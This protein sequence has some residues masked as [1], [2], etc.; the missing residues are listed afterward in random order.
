MPKQTKELERHWWDWLS[1][2]ERLLRSLHEQTAALTLRRIERVEQIQP[3]LESMMKLMSEIDEQAA[4]SARTLAEELGCEPNLRSLVEALEKPEAE[5]V[6]AI[7]NRVIVVGRN[8]QRV[9]DKNKAL[10]EREMECVNGT[11][12]LVAK[13]VAEDE[14]PYQKRSSQASILMNQVA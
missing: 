9:I 6:Q 1:T 3:E 10:I 14:T 7:A 8:V 5:Q 13:E 12:A 11:L 2:A 4:A